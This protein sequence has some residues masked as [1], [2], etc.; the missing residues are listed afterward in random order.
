[1]SLVEPRVMPPARRA[2]NRRNARE[3]YASRWRWKTMLILSDGGAAPEGPCAT[4]SEA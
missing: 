3:I 2:S 1:M 4:P